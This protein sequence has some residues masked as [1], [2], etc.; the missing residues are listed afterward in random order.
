[1]RGVKNMPLPFYTEYAI[2]RYCEER[3][4]HI[5]TNWL[6]CGCEINPICEIMRE[7]EA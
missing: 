4:K 2:I 7:Q 5:S 1:M 3:Q 6:C